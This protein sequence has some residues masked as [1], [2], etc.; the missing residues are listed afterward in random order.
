MTDKDIYTR[1]LARLEIVEAE[2]APYPHPEWTVEALN[3]LRALLV[4]RQVKD[5]LNIVLPGDAAT[6]T[7]EA[8]AVLRMFVGDNL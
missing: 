1:A 3:L 5:S 2:T 4:E 7:L 8:D 6:V